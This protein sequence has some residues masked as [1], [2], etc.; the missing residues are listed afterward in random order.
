MVGVA[1]IVAAEF[2][3]LMDFWWHYRKSQGIRSSDFLLGGLMIRGMLV[4]LLVEKILVS[5]K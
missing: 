3:M 5:F 2:W 4:I 1:L